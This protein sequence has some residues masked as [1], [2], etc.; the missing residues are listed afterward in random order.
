MV[1]EFIKIKIKEN[2]AP[3]APSIPNLIHDDGRKMVGGKGSPKITYM[4]V[5]MLI[6]M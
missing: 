3:L 1:E 2:Y 5:T 6:C 4:C